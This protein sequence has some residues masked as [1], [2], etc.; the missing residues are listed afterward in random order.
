MNDVW[1]I[2]FENLRWYE[3]ANV[4]LVCKYWYESTKKIRKKFEEVYKFHYLPFDI[5]NIGIYMKN[6]MYKYDKKRNCIK[7]FFEYASKISKYKIE[8]K[9]N[10]Y[11]KDYVALQLRLESESLVELPF[12]LKNKQ[13]IWELANKNIIFKEYDIFRKKITRN[14]GKINEYNTFIVSFIL[15]NLG[16]CTCSIK[17]NVSDKYPAEQ[18]Y[19]GLSNNSNIVKELYS[20]YFEKIMNLCFGKKEIKFDDFDRDVKIHFIHDQPKNRLN[21]QYCY[22]IYTKDK[23]NDDIISTL[24]KIIFQSR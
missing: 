1:F 15:N 22:K 18:L 8:V 12:N 24:K 14:F 16:N 20:S 6:K 3:L 2:I 10:V 5:K 4:S 19:R 21:Y 17:I 7:Y 9:T 13:K 11:S 23:I